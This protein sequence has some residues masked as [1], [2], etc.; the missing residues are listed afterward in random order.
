MSEALVANENF[1]AQTTRVEEKIVPSR[2]ARLM[3]AVKAIYEA[4]PDWGV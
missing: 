3:V 2:L 1:D 4:H